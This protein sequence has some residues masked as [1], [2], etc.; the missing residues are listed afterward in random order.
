MQLDG[1]IPGFIRRNDGTIGIRKKVP[2]EGLS[3]T[4]L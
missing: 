1:S 3:Y 4:I 2:A